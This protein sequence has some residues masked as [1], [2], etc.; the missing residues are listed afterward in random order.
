[1]LFIQGGINKEQ[2]EVF[3]NMSFYDIQ[4]KKWV[5]ASQQTS[6]KKVSIGK[7]YMHSM[8]LVVSSKIDY[9]VSHYLTITHV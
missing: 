2:M 1:M 3:D 9:K 4:N 8:T 6:N 7:R 5:G